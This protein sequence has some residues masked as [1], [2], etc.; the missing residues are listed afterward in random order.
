MSINATQVTVVGKVVSDI[1]T[2]TIPSG[3]R[4]TNFRLLAQERV[5]DKA[6]QEW[7]DGD[8]MYLRIACWRKLA[9]N[10]AESLSPGDHVVVTGRLRLRE[11]EKDGDRHKSLEVEARSVGPDLTLHTVMVN[12]PPWAVSPDQQELVHPTPVQPAPDEPDEDL[13]QADVVQAA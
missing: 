1:E 11:Y 3:V 13:T 5:F 8:R 10:V 7:A 9:E 4:V 12:R 6:R 2:R